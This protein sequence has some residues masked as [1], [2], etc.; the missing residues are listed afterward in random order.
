MESRILSLPK[1]TRENVPT[2]LK[3]YQE[4]STFH[5]H[6]FSNSLQKIAVFW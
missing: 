6:G 2:F 1:N 3:E 4:N 5:Q